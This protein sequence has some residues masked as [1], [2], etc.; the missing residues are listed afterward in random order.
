VVCAFVSEGRVVIGRSAGQVTQQLPRSLE[1]RESCVEGKLEEKTR[2]VL[3]ETT[4]RAPTR[5]CLCPF[6][7]SDHT[8][9]GP[10]F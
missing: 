7:G 8:Q 6:I 2:R 9:A 4:H 3:L 5:R 10:V 1:V